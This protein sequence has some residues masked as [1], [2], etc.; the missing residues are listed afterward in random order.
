MRK[1]R[2]PRP[3]ERPAMRPSADARHPTRTAFA[4]LLVGL[5]SWAA[6]ATASPPTFA[7]PIN[8]SGPGPWTTRYDGYHYLAATTWGDSSVGLTMRKART[9]DGLK[10]AEQVQVWQDDTPDRCCNYWA[11]EFFLLGSDLPCQRRSRRCLR[12]GPYAA[13]PEIYPERRRFAELRCD[14]GRGYGSHSTIAQ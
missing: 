11:P 6:L 7:N 12:Y 5:G 9:I 14:S 8:A 4:G 13:H 2:N 1:Y 3:G 10:Q